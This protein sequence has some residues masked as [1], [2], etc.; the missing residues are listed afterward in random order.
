MG[1]T[2]L[3]K[4]QTMKTYYWLMII[5]FVFCPFV[6]AQQSQVVTGPEV[7]TNLIKPDTR[8][9]T[10]DF[11]GEKK[12]TNPTTKQ[13][14]PDFWNNKTDTRAFDAGYKAAK[15][16]DFWSNKPQPK[17]QQKSQPEA[18][19]NASSKKSKCGEWVDGRQLLRIE[20]VDSG[21]NIRFTNVSQVPI[22]YEYKRDGCVGGLNQDLA[23][24]KSSTVTNCSAKTPNNI[25][26]YAMPAN[27]FIY[28]KCP[29][30]LDKPKPKPKPK[31]EY[32]DDLPFIIEA[33]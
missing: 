4:K 1:D 13:S 2:T 22:T 15:Q 20:I 10:D 6:K 12:T 30:P 8:S 27:E 32:E 31:K 14:T 29:S 5:L 33:Y 19:A 25:V 26:C 24:G 21:R 3:K 23:P 16:N 11:W 17:A 18:T 9:Y 7:N 28:G